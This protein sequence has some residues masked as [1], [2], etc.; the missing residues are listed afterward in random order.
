M[1]NWGANLFL[2][3]CLLLWVFAISERPWDAVL[4]S[5]E[6]AGSSSCIAVCRTCSDL[7]ARSTIIPQLL[8]RL[9]RAFSLTERRDDAQLNAV[10]YCPT[11]EEYYDRSPFCRIPLRA[12]G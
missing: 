2:F 3:P 6:N 4:E 9:E 12:E 1:A 5:G 10:L 11:T 7:T 8:S